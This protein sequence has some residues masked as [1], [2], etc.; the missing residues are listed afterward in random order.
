MT[1]VYGPC[2]E[3]AR[4]EFI[5]WFKNHHILDTDNWLFLGD[6]NFYRSLQ[7]RNK[8]GGNIADTFV[9]NDAIGHLG[10]IE[11][12]LKGRAYT[13][14]NMQNDP[15]L[16]QL[17]WFFT[18]VNWTTEYPNSEVLPMAKITSDHIPCKVSIGTNI[19]RSSLFRFENFW[20]EHEGFMDT[21]LSQWNQAVP[22]TSMAR[23]IYTKFKKL[24]NA[25]KVWSRG[26]SNLSQLIANCNEVI[27]F[28][29]GLEDR[30]PLYNTES[31]LRHLVKCQLA[32][33]LHYKN[34]YW[35]KRYTVN[36]IRFGDEC[37]KFFHAMATIS[38]RRNYIP[39]LLN[40]QGQ[41][42]Q[43]HEGKAGLLWNAF[44]KTH[45]GFDRAYD[46]L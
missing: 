8:P 7:N 39:Q 46:A 13:W 10:L 27:L 22:A 41:W 34:A 4:S 3:P 20:V 30:R 12:Q 38:H 29:D 31:N 35:K 15:L 28:L 32:T 21:V 18:S 11:L 44:K 45:G 14:S 9:F 24:R 33:L 36:R 17:D 16:E 19:P 26:L 2:T 42:V 40:D 37:T 1:T 6:F 23:S 5:T 25:L 43:D